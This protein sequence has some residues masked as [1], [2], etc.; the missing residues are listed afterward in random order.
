MGIDHYK[1]L[2]VCPNASPEVVSAAWKALAKKY[3][4]DEPRLKLVNNAKDILC[5]STHRQDYDADRNLVKKGK[6]IQGYRILQKI[7]EG[8][9]GTTYKAEHVATGCPVC[10]K[11]ASE[12][13]AA[14]TEMLLAEARAVWDLRH[15]GIPSMRDV[16]KMDDGSL[17]L[18]MSYIP[19]LTLSQILE[20]PEYKH[21]LDPEHVAWITE[22]L[23]NILRYLHINKVVHGDIKPQNVIVQSELH[24]VVLVDYGLSLV[25]PKKTDKAKGY[26]PYFAAPEQLE[27]KVPIPETD[28]YG[29]GMTMIF[30]LGGDIEFIK[31]PGPTPDG[32]CG[33]IKRFIKRNVLSRPN[34]SE[35]L[36]ETI[37]EVRK[38]DFGRSA[39]DMK[40]LNI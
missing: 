10:I 22:R 38:V 4:K 6:V 30:A 8:G 11:H 40:P 31:V 15:W 14:D 37:K 24:T 39:S 19:G 33:L 1:I 16:I 26:T 20:K 18:V 32:L 35:D 2:E 34:W 29:L 17:G 12:I 7:A 27:G 9:F 23:L 3:Q 25:Q 36:C 28:F 13:S 21:G 5:D